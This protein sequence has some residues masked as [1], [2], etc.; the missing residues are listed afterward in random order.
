M[1]STE[2]VVFSGVFLALIV[3]ALIS[4]RLFNLERKVAH[5]LA[6]MAEQNKRALSLKKMA[7]VETSLT[8]LT[9]AYDALLASHKKLR[10]RI[11]MRANRDAKKESELPD[12]R[13]DPAGYKREMRLRLAN[14][15]GK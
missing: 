12:P 6:Y 4:L 9:D 1:L 10:S 3:V 14:I 8:E 7:E 11:G 13:E 15:N 5:A 2:I